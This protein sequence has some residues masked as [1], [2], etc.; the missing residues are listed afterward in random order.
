MEELFGFITARG[1]ATQDLRGLGK[2]SSN[3]HKW[4]SP[5]SRFQQPLIEETVSVTLGSATGREMADGE[6]SDRP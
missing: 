6:T 2:N 4:T 5:V 3:G 1:S